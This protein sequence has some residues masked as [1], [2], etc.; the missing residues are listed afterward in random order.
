[1]EQAFNAPLHE[2]LCCRAERIVSRTGPSCTARSAQWACVGCL[3]DLTFVPRRPA[4]VADPFLPDAIFRADGRC[5]FKADI[6]RHQRAA[7][8][9]RRLPL[10][11]T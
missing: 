9:S 4:A 2:S 11:P 6:G 3:V 5:N 8:M 10:V 7:T 1:M